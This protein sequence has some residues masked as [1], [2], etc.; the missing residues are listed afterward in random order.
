MSY[1]HSLTRLPTRTDDEPAAFQQGRPNGRVP[2]VEES[3][4]SFRLLQ[5][6]ELDS[7]SSSGVGLVQ[8]HQAHHSRTWTPIPDVL[9]DNS[10]ALDQ[11]PVIYNEFVDG[12]DTTPT[13]GPTEPNI[14]HDYCR[15]SNDNAPI[16]LWE[17]EQYPPAENNVVCQRFDLNKHSGTDNTTL[18]P[19]VGSWPVINL[20]GLSQDPAI[21]NTSELGNMTAPADLSR[22]YNTEYLVDSW[23]DERFPLTETIVAYPQI[24]DTNS[25][26]DNITLP[27]ESSRWNR[28]PR[29]M[30]EESNASYA[31]PHRP[32]RGGRACDP[33]TSL[34]ELVKAQPRVLGRSAKWDTSLVG[35][36]QARYLAGL[37]EILLD[38]LC[39][40]R[41]AS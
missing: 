11:P 8:G 2:G 6:A 13:F 5:D 20:L 4:M 29:T 19:E 7:S 17:N 32:Q 10:F 37:R 41:S 28:E 22:F 31:S 18:T 16:N 9:G 39:K 34:D 25:G 35:G 36:G 26:P 27:P 40:T 33:A 23:T 38:R 30:P 24:G 3:K 15:F 14:A 12:T 21:F 1:L